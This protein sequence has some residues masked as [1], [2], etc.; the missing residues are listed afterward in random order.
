MSMTATGILTISTISLTCAV[1]ITG[2]IRN[3]VWQGL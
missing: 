1:A 2:A 3:K